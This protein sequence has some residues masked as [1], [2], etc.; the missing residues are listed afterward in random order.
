MCDAS[1]KRD[2][3]SGLLDKFVGKSVTVKILNIETCMSEQTVYILIRL[4]LRSSLIRIYT[5][6]HSFY[7]FWRHYF[8]VKLNCF[9]LRTTTVASLGVP[10]L[11]VFT[12]VQITEISSELYHIYDLAY[13]LFSKPTV[14]ELSSPMQVES[15]TVQIRSF[16]TRVPH[17]VVDIDAINDPLKCPQYAQDICDY[18][19]VPYLFG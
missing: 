15:P 17:G 16:M 3:F 14:S 12:V 11:R 1:H 13:K 9:I 6:C 4:L 5:V 8:I 18:L 10:I 7:I 19:Q 2:G